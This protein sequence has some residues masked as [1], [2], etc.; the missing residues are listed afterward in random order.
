MSVFPTQ[1]QSLSDSL[2]SSISNLTK[3]EKIEVIVNLPF[4]KTVS[5]ISDLEKLTDSAIFW[6]KELQDTLLLAQSYAKKTAL[7]HFTTKIGSMI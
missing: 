7:L 3:S 5:D 6:S 2:Y 4:D 1:S